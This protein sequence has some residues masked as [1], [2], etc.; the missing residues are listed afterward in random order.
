MSRVPRLHKAQT[1]RGMSS[2]YTMDSPTVSSI[3]ISYQYGHLNATGASIGEFWTTSYSRA[4]VEH[5]VPAS[6]IS[7][8]DDFW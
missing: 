4:S 7:I 8:Q 1:Q 2:C 6:M 5:L 3:T